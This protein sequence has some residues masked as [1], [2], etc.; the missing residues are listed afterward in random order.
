VFLKAKQI[1][2]NS[3]VWLYV[4]TSHHLPVETGIWNGTP[5]NERLCHPCN[6]NTVGDEYHYLMECDSFK[7]QRKIAWKPFRL[8]TLKFSNL[9]SSSNY[10]LQK[11]LSYSF[12][13]Y[14]TLLAHMQYN[15][16]RFDIYL[17]I[18]CI[19]KCKNPMNLYNLLSFS[20][21]VL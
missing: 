16:I 5:R 17:I 11:K 7:E 4:L 19:T 18:F 15:I 20:L 9:M 1:K 21:V 12:L 6:C 8:N 2:K 10:S 14:Q 3:L 13:K